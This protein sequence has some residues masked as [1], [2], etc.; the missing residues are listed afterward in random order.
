M[1][2]HFGILLDERTGLRV[3]DDKS[4]QRGLRDYVLELR[5]KRPPC[6][7]SL[8]GN[9]VPRHLG[10]VAL[11]VVDLAVVGHKYDLD[12]VFVLAGLD[13]FP[14]ILLQEGGITTRRR[15]PVRTKV[16]ADVLEALVLG[17]RE[18]LGNGEF[19]VVWLDHIVSEKTGSSRGVQFHLNL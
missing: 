13:F 19:G 12:E 4:R 9:R 8:E 1:D 10:D 15:C 14:E 3:D 2:V 6:G 7:L 17:L 16:Q 18:P 11:E 5:H